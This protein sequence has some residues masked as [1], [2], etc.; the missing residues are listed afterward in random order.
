MRPANREVANGRRALLQQT[1]D[2]EIRAEHENHYSKRLLDP[3]GWKP[4]HQAG[5]GNRPDRGY[6]REPADEPPIES[7][8]SEI[9]RNSARRVHRDDEQRAADGLPHGQMGD[10]H[11]RG[12]DEKAATG[13]DESRQHANRDRLRAQERRKPRRIP[14]GL[15]EAD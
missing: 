5:A 8:L 3:R 15:G 10:Q 12:H 1:S 13:A 9:A 11:E 14:G 6:T 4:L 7:Y 2:H